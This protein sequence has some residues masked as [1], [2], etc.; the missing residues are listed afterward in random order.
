MLQS[1][2]QEYMIKTYQDAEMSE[3][4]AG[5]SGPEDEE[6]HYSDDEEG[7]DDEEEEGDGED[8]DEEEEQDGFNQDTAR[9]SQLAVGYKDR[10]F[11]VRGNK[12]GVF[13]HND[14]DGLEFATTIKNLSNSKGREI[15]PTRV[16]LCYIPSTATNRNVTTFLILFLPFL[17]LYCM[18]KIPLW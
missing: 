5:E 14:R 17:R 9:N 8:E 6:E 11:V 7:S 2:D 16:S 3:S 12:I 1:A 18:S 13:K 4:D 10:S 15:N